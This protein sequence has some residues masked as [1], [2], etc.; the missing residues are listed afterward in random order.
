MSGIVT[1]DDLFPLKANPSP[2]DRVFGFDTE[3]G[4]SR[5]FSLQSILDLLEDSPVNWDDIEGKPL[6]FAPSAHT[7]GSHSNV[8]NSVDAAADGTFLKKVGGQVTAVAVDFYGVS[9]PPPADATVPEPVR[10][11]SAEKIAQWDQAYGWGNHAGQYRPIGW[12]PSWTQ[13][14]GKPVTFAPSAHGLASHS[15]AA[16]LATAIEGQ[17]VRKAAIGFEAF[18]A[19]YYSPGNPPPPDASIP[20]FVR[21]FTIGQFAG[22]EAKMLEF[23]GLPDGAIPLIKGGI[24]VTS[25]ILGIYSENPFD[26]ETETEDYDAWVEELLHLISAK[27]IKGVDA[28][29][30]DELA[31]LGQIKPP[32]HIKYDSQPLMLAGQADQ[33]EGYAY[34][35]G[36]K[37]WRKL[38]TSTGLIAD[39]REMGGAGGGGA[40]GNAVHYNA[41]DGKSVTEKAQARANIGSTSM[42]AQTVS[43]TGQIANLVKTSNFIVFT[44][45]GAQ[46]SGIA[47]G[48]NGEEVLI[49]NLTGGDMVLRVS[50]SGNLSSTI[51]RITNSD[52]ANLSIANNTFVLLKYDGSRWREDFYG[53]TK[54]FVSALV[55]SVKKGSLSLANSSGIIRFLINQDTTA[56]SDSI[57]FYGA[58]GTSKHF[59]IGN[60]GAVSI[61]NGANSG[62]SYLDA[63]GNLV[64]GASRGASGLSGESN[65]YRGRFIE[66]LRAKKYYSDERSAI[67]EESI[68]RDEQRLYY[69]VNVTTAGIIHNQ[70]ITPG[71]FNYRFTAAT[72]LTGIEPIDEDAKITIQN[73]NTLNLDLPHESA[74]SIA[75]NRFNWTGGATLSIPPKGKIE[76][77]RCSG[78]R[79]ELVSK[80]F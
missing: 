10:G 74:G 54:S 73:D 13:V 25:E 35:D 38:A 58:D 59:V 20:D 17:L 72:S 14:T 78:S 11:I 4:K 12:V 42:S 16:A 75:A 28:V 49:H 6:T 31:T 43:A 18:T 47:D 5:G 66:R 26:P 24:P 23:S 19:D 21:E 9:N 8:A 77:M 50:S 45:S 62:F 27:R 7:I 63:S 37:E 1:F 52:F 2:L 29:E 57:I 51:N 64:F 65:L 67:A 76:I 3:D 36:T 15:D 46:L 79:Y 44:G 60:Q 30:L 80:N 41:A 32:L 69:K 40:D 55:N 56:F 33:K 39:Y 68:R 22:Y 61:G 34:W 53:L 70:P 48:V 71:I